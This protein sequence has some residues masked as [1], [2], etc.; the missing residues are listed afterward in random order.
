MADES[1]PESQDGARST[2]ARSIAYPFIPLETAISRA[3]QFWQQERKNAAPISAAASHWGFGEKSSGG[4]QTVAALIQYGLMNDEGSKEGRLVRLT[5][6]GIDLAILPPDDAKRQ[7]LIQTAARAPKIYSEL[8]SKWEELPSDTTLKYFLL[9]EKNFNP[10]SVDG[11]IKDFR[12]TVSFAKLSKPDT[13]PATDETPP[14]PPPP[15]A[16][17][18]GDVVQWTSGGVDQLPTPRTVTKITDD[19]EFAYVDGPHTASALPIK[20]L[21]V[22]NNAQNSG[23]PQVDIPSVASPAAAV[24]AF[25]VR[26][27]G[28]K[29]DVFSLDEGQ[30]VL[31][32]PDGMSKNSFDDFK[33][34]IDL[35]LR[36]IGRSIQ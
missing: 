35:Q 12:K 27:A 24:A 25:V 26:K 32:W 33:D 10:N 34:W 7:P 19:G 2:G 17:K 9:K 8:L 36:K 15:P 20:E 3:A 6:G 13:M 5:D 18:V 14:P 22:M 16:V 29:Q 21:T 11:F 1:K 4:R 23:Q 30:V 28:T 31:Q